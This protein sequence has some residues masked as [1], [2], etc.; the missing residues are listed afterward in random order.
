MTD[1]NEACSSHVGILDIQS[2]KQRS[3]GRIGRRVD[4]LQRQLVN[5]IVDVG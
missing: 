4:H 3:G 2:D 1:L 5:F